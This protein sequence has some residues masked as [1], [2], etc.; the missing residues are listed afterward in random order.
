MKNNAITCSNKGWNTLALNH[1]MADDHIKAICILAFLKYLE[2]HIVGNIQTC[3]YPAIN[4]CT[5]KPPQVFI[6]SL[7]NDLCFPEKSQNTQY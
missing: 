6:L 3:T 2:A 5:S 4:H 1:C 7:A